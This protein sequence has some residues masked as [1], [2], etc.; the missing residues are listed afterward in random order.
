MGSVLRE[1]CRGAVKQRRGVLEA[2][3]AGRDTFM[4]PQL[5]RTTKNSLFALRH[6]QC[7][8]PYWTVNPRDFPVD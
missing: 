8:C 7:S 1:E 3:Q 4:A 5:P 6:C 2:G